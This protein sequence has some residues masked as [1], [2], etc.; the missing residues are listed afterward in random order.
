M[1]S[2]DLAKAD[3]RIRGVFQIGKAILERRFPAFEVRPICTYR[4]PAEQLVEF[5]AGRSQLDG[6]KKASKHNSNPALAIDFGI[7]RKSDGAY[8]D[9][10]VTK[11]QFA[12]E[13]RD[14]LYWIF[15]LT[16]QRNGARWGGD[17]DGDGIP[18][19]V[20][21]NEH[22]NDDDHIEFVEART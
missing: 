21:D 5:K 22:L 20:D 18:V 8:L 2:R 1:A 17:W 7:F 15:G 19:A 13:H 11:G 12:R 6:T 9:D 16:A 10:L 3:E 4:S 14:A